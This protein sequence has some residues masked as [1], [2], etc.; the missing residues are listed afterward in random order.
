MADLWDFAPAKNKLVN[1]LLLSA[2]GAFEQ[3]F[4][5]TLLLYCNFNAVFRQIQTYQTQRFQAMQVS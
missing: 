1:C 2:A 3:G 5:I 4:Q